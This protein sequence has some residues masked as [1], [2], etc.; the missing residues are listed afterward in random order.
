MES[1]LSIGSSYAQPSLKKSFLVARR[2]TIYAWLIPA[3]MKNSCDLRCGFDLRAANGR[4]R[5][6]RPTRGRLEARAEQWQYY[7]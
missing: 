7:G 5:L 2:P 3:A 6:Q 1:R 4:K